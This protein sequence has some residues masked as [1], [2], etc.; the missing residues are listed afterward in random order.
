MWRILFFIFCYDVWFYIS[1]LLLHHKKMW[2]IHKLHHSKH[3]LVYSDIYLA[4]W[5]ESVFQSFGLL[6]S[7]VYLSATMYELMIVI[8]FL[9]GRG[10]MRHDPRCVSIVGNHHLLHHKYSNYNFGEHWLDRIFGT[11]YP[12]QAEYKYGWLYI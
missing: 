9:N 2:F 5:F 12:I 3:D 10:M 7:I 11:Q 8:I 4:H 1:H 6:L